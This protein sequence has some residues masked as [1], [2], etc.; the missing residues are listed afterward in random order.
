MEKNTNP[1]T[2]NKKPAKS[3]S[4]LPKN[5]YD[6]RLFEL[7]KCDEEIELAKVIH[8]HKKIKADDIH[9]ARY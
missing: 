1:I 2:K 9:Q 5:E 3:V 7:L 4:K 8:F 6:E